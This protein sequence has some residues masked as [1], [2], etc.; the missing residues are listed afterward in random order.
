MNTALRIAPHYFVIDSIGGMNEGYSDT[1][2]RRIEDV[3]APELAKAMVEEYID[4]WIHSTH[5]YYSG[6]CDELGV[7]IK[8]IKVIHDQCKHGGWHRVCFAPDHFSPELAGQVDFESAHTLFIQVYD[9]V[10]LGDG[11]VVYDQ[12]DDMVRT[13]THKSTAI[14]MAEET[15]SLDVGRIKTRLRD[16]KDTPLVRNGYVT[17]LIYAYDCL[18]E[19]VRDLEYPQD[20]MVDIDDTCTHYLP[21]QAMKQ[22][23]YT[24]D[25]RITTL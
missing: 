2:C 22:M 10:M 8:H 9:G 14:R 13:I 5:E 20:V 21:I 11:V 16:D 1:T 15:I 7:D 12:M 6:L 19:V 17:N 23:V 25:N 24:N 4:Q 18:A 3:K